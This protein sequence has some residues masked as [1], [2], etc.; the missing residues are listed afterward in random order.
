MDTQIVVRDDGTLALGNIPPVRASGTPDVGSLYAEGGLFGT[1]K[2]DPTLVNAIVG[3]EGFE[4][5][6]RWFGTDI[7][8]PIYQSLT[9]IG[10]TSTA[11]ASECADCGNDNPMVLEFDHVRGK[12]KNNISNMVKSYYSWRSISDEINKCDIVCANCHKI[13][14]HAQQGTYKYNALTS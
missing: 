13:R 4:K 6:L 7:E 5:V 9:Y 8:N 12:K 11:Q 3:P 2:Q 14:T 10:T 1:C